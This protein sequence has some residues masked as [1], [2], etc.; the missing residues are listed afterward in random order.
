VRRPS[1]KVRI[2]RMSTGVLLGMEGWLDKLPDFVMRELR[3]AVKTELLARQ[4]ATLAEESGGW[5]CIAV[6][7]LQ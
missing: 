3:E 6:G 2:S 5:P 4:L 7:G 1:I